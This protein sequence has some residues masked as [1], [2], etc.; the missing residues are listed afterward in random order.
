MIII[1][2]IKRKYRTSVNIDVGVYYQEKNYQENILQSVLTEFYQLYH[3]YDPLF[4]VLSRPDC[5][6]FNFRS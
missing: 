2:C 1:I 3:R 6:L 5:F 4:G